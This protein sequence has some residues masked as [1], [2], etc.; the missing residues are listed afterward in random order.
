MPSTTSR[1]RTP[2]I[3]RQL[4]VELLEVTPSIWRRLLVP[5]DIKLPT[6]HQVLQRTLGWTDSHLHQFS[7]NG[8]EYAE[9]DPEWSDELAHSDERRVRLQEVLPGTTRCFDYVY[10]FGDH[11]HHVVIVEDYYAQPAGA[12]SLVRCLDGA[13]AVPPEDVGGT[14]GY[15]EFLEAIADPSHEEHDRY[16]EWAGGA[17]DP[18]HFDIAAVNKS[19][20]KMKV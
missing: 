1:R 20:S 10:D 7:I 6:L 17:F 16:L 18:A 2:R 9:F 12:R 11:W 4:R 13:N 14:S 3:A 19:L 8:V 15:A 5:S